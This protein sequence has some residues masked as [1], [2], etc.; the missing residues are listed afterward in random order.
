[1]AGGSREAGGNLGISPENG[2]LAKH[3][4]IALPT[5]GHN[6]CQAAPRPRRSYA[7]ARD[8]QNW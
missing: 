2:N 1:M 5:P 4:I 6:A 8:T 3:A 7:P